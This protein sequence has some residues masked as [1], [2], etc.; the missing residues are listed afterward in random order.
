MKLKSSLWDAERGSAQDDPSKKL[1]NILRS[2]L[3]KSQYVRM[4]RQ[5]L[6]YIRRGDIYQANLSQRFSLNTNGLTGQID[7]CRIYQ[8]LRELSPSHFGGYFNCRNFQIVSSSPE[9]FL[10]LRGRS[11]ETRPMKGTRPRADDQRRDQRL[12][13][14]LRQSRKDQAELLMITD[15]ERNDLGR[16]CDYGSVKV[17]CMRTL[18]EYQTVFQATSTIEGKL[19]KDK[20]PFDLLRACF[21]GGSITGCPKI[22]AMEII[23]ELEPGRRGIYTGSM[24]YIS[25]SGAMDFNILIRTLLVGRGEITFHVGG[26]IVAD[27][28]PEKEYAETLVKAKAMQECLKTL[29]NPISFLFLDGKFVDSNARLL[30]QLTPGIIKEKGVFETLRAYDGTLSLLDKHLDRLEKGLRELQIP[31]PYSQVEIRRHLQETLRVNGLRN[32]R[33]RLM[34][35]QGNKVR[36]AIIA[37]PYQPFP[38]KKYKKGFH[39]VLSDLRCDE[40]S[41]LAD[42]KSIQYQPFY[43]AYKKIQ[44]KKY[45][46]AILLNRKGE[47]VEGSRSNIFFIKNKVLFTPDLKSGCLDGITRRVVIDLARRF[48]LPVQTGGFKPADLSSAEE[49]FLTNSLWEI[50]PLTTFD[51]R[52]IGNG[53][54]GKITWKLME[55]MKVTLRSNFP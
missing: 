50:M 52:R 45:D 16:V 42:I 54:P 5:A 44:N 28:V 31:L 34:V 30:E 49:S 47:I 51:H 9:R 4:V 35:W 3:S 6:D 17:S 1:E 23:E 48:G 14:E 8:R 12:R 32:A 7:P 25:F 19:R 38:L 26:G 11:V 53:K 13:Q 15:L 41:R 2:Q 33:V 18:E 36:V 22:R 27:S 40:Q 21:P 20:N 43:S 24:G 29:A 37:Q 55:M 39:A 10:S 46:E